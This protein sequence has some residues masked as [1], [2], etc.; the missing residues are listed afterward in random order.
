MAATALSTQIFVTFL[1]IGVCSC[2]RRFRLSRSD[3]TILGVP[4][5]SNEDVK[6]FCALMSWFKPHQKIQC[7]QH[8]VLMPSVQR[9]VENALK[10]CPKHFRDHRWNCTGISTAQV[11][12][13]KGMMET[14]SR[15]SAYAYAVTAAGV[16]HEITRGCSQENWKECGCDKRM[17]GKVAK[18]KREDGWEWGGCS[19]NVKYGYEF[20]RRFMDPPKPRDTSDTKTMLAYSLNVHNNEVGRRVSRNSI[21]SF[22]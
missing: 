7:L 17:R 3:S 21:C 10:E 8:P 12:Q 19:D 9:G 20:A 15:E 5:S 1:L 11:F 6:R 2:R 18:S 22:P 13:G 14:K 16:T 4:L